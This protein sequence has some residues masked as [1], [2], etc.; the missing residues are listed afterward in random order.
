MKASMR[1]LSPVFNTNRMVAEYA[2]RFYIPASRRNV[3]L[4]ANDAERVRPL[5]DWRRRLRDHGSEVR[6]V[7]VEVQSAAEIFVGSPMTVTA[8]V[9]LGKLTPADVRV[10]V[11]HGP[12]DAE[13]RVSK[14]EVLDLTRCRSVDRDHLYQGELECRDSGSR[15]LAV[16]V[17]AF[18][19]D[20]ILPYEQPWL[21]WES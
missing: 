14:G 9:F 15:G 5:V 3:K 8:R 4:R 20:A 12:L 10:Q 18:H 17:V 7:S 13:G 19:E 21:V 11:F 2:E 6:V 1:E 16:R